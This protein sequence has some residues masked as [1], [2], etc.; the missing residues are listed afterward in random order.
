MDPY[1]E[2]TV[3]KTNVKYRTKVMKNAGQFVTFSGEHFPFAIR[4]R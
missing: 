4:E 3:D 1:C 2:V